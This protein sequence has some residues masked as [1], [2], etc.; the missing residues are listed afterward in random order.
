MIGV[1][2]Y[3]L[4]T[5]SYQ[6]VEF[7]R[8]DYILLIISIVFI[9]AGGNMINDY[10]D[11]KADRINKPHRV[12]VEKFIKKRWV[13]ILHWLINVTALLI[14]IYLSYKYKTLLFVFIHLI[15]INALWFYSTYIKRKLFIG[16]LIIALLTGLV[17]IL[18]V[19]YFQILNESGLEHS[20]YHKETWSVFLNYNYIYFIAISAFLINLAREIIKDSQDIEGDKH[21]GVKSIPMKLGLK[22]ANIIALLFLQ[23]PTIIGYLLYSNSY[24]EI[25][26]YE[27]IFL[28]CSASINLMIMA[29]YVIFDTKNLKT[30]HLFIKLSMFIGLL[31]LFSPFI[32]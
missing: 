22:K 14:S 10:F 19:W 27:W 6:Y 7:N 2:D 25:Y 5:H 18:A 24:F 3:L 26:N 9:A 28:L 29:V 15:S 1:A 23:I 16:N 21:I 11:L 30:I 12:I 4:L 8:M 32:K 20:P 13:I 17:P 31:S